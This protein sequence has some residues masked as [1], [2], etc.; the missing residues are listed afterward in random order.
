MHFQNLDTILSYFKK[1]HVHNFNIPEVIASETCGYF[2]ALKLCGNHPVEIN[3][4]RGPK[5]C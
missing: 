2:N 4:L 5:H 1:D 3:V